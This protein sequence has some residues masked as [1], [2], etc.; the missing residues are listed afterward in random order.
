LTKNLIF[1]NKNMGLEKEFESILETILAGEIYARIASVAKSGISRRILFYR[2]D[3]T[4]GI[5]GFKR[6][7]NYIENITYEIGL[8][9]GELKSEQYKQGGKCVSESGFRVN[10]C[11][12]DMVFKYAL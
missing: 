11:G 7:K 12:M 10:G 6:R 5:K 4:S 3:R 2:I 1:K 8:L 9:S